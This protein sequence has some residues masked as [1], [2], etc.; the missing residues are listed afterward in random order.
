MFTSKTYYIYIWLDGHISDNTYTDLQFAAQAKLGAIQVKSTDNTFPGDTGTT[1][2][3]D[4][5]EYFNYR[6][7]YI[8]I[9]YNSQYVLC[10]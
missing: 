9:E 10:L 1:L 7:L 6:D 8:P 4:M 5:Y 3:S 2:T